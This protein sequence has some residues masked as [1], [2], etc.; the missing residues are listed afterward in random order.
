MSKTKY[1]VFTLNNYTEQEKTQLASTVPTQLQY[2][3]FGEEVGDS[4]TP[5]LQGYAESSQ[6]RPLT[7]WRSLFFGRAHLEKRK[8][9][10]CQA[11]DYCQKDGL[12]VEYGEIST[13]SQGKRSDLD[14]LHDSLVAKRSMVDISDDHF[15]SFLR[16]QRSIQ[17]YRYYHARRRTWKTRVVVLVGPTRT[18]KTALAHLKGGVHLWAAD[19]KLVWFDGYYEDDYVLFDEFSGCSCDIKYLLRLLDRYPMQV[20]V[21]GGY[22][23]WSPRVVFIATNI[24]IESWYPNAREEHRRALLRRLEEI[25]IL[26]QTTFDLL[27]WNVY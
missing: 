19:T 15:G 11:R 10:S 24:P 14:D 17:T 26:D 25:T 8:G 22:T 1:Q 16:Y 7:W 13:S 3:V 27:K 23:Q 5:H 20:P 21:K 4:G 12:S 18:R 6:R 2:I 9:T